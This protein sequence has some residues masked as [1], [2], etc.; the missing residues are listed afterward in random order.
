MKPYQRSFVVEIKSTRRRSKMPPKSIWGDTDIKALAREA[1]AVHPSAQAT[2]SGASSQPVDRPSGQE[3]VAEPAEVIVI[4][5]AP[6]GA[7]PAMD[8]NLVQ[9]EAADQ[10]LTDNASVDKE[11]DAP[12]R[13]FPTP[14]KRRRGRKLKAYAD[15]ENRR[16]DGAGDQDQHQRDELSLLEEENRHL[17]L[18]LAE[19]LHRQNVELRQKLKR[20]DAN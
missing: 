9:A 1:E 18:R 19:Q 8:A 14:V 20:F 12:E 17:K 11:L 5:N 2:V 10:G 13:L 3:P 4:A 6:Q 16:I 15:G 7:S